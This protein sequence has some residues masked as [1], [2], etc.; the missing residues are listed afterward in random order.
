MEQ[1]GK[2]EKTNAELEHAIDHASKMAVKAQQ[3]N[4]AKSQFLATMSH[5]IRTP[6][7]GVVGMADLLL[8]TSLNAQQRTFADVIKTSATI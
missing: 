6:L 1:K 5:E 2:T 3:A 8:D 4:V 7:N